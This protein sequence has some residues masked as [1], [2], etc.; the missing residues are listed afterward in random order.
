MFASMKSLTSLKMGHV[1]SKTRSFGQTLEK[2]CVESR[3]HIASPIL[4]KLCQNVCLHEIRHKF[5][6]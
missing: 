3:G 5:E 1:G 2:P 6:N 4:M